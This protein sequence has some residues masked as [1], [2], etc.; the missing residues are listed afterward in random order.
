[1]QFVRYPM[2]YE[3]EGFNYKQLNQLP[4]P[5]HTFES[6][7]SRGFGPDGTLIPEESAERLLDRMIALDK[8][9]LKVGMPK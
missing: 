7:D 8:V 9:T 6:T 3:V 1:M 5:A 2:K 4:T